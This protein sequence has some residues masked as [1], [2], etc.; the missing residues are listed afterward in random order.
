MSRP[1]L[2]SFCLKLLG[3]YAL[4][5]S[6]PIL[7]MHVGYMTSLLIEPSQQKLVFWSYFF[8]AL[9]PFVLYV[10]A[11]II[12]LTL[13]PRIA[14][15]IFRP[16]EESFLPST[17][18]I[19]D[20]QPIGF[21]IVAV[22]I[23]ILTFPKILSFCF[24][25]WHISQMPEQT[26]ADQIATLTGRAFKTGLYALIQLILALLLFFRAQGLANLW[27]RIQIARYVKISDL[28]E[29]NPPNTADK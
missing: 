23:F 15:L 11:G 12:L 26:P 14:R 27:H 22:L 18:N 2:G 16:D 10:T 20:L 17:V 28:P 21:S 4:L 29:N 9:F 1:S 6:L 7:E 24:H 13:A 19:D 3:I 25:L 8:S 5:K